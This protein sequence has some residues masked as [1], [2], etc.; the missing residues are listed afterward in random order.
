MGDEHR[1]YSH[2]SCRHI[3][4]QASFITYLRQSREGLMCRVDGVLD[5]AIYL[6]VITTGESLQTQGVRYP[7][8]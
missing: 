2:V 5:Q 7:I 6:R 8:G 3:P 1:Y 4:T